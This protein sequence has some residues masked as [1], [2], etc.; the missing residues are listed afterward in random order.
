[1]IDISCKNFTYK[2]Y[3]TYTYFTKFYFTKF[4][5]QKLHDI[6][7]HDIYYINLVAAIIGQQ[8]F[9]LTWRELPILAVSHHVK[10]RKNY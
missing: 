4:Y 9:L 6:Y 5:L 8:K 2:N 10:I 3:M 1:M 7:I